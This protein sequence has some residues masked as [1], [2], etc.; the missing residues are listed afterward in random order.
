MTKRERC[1][2][3]IGWHSFAYGAPADMESIKA[4]LNNQYLMSGEVVEELVAELKK[5]ELITYWEGTHSEGWILSDE[6]NSGA[7]N[8]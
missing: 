2:H 7:T 8:E 5:A 1:L 4:I 6:T 3:Y